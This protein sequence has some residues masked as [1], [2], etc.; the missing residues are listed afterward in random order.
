MVTNHVLN[1]LP[2][3]TTNACVEYPMMLDSQENGSLV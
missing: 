2:S 1:K 3:G